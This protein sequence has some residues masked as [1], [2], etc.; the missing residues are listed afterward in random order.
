MFNNEKI[1]FGYSYVIFPKYNLL[2]Y[3]TEEHINIYNFYLYI[4]EM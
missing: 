2:S 3:K 1:I 4:K